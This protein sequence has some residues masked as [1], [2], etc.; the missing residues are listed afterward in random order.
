M[1][2]RGTKE[3]TSRDEVNKLWRS[4][5]ESSSRRIRD[6]CLGDQ[7]IV[8]RPIKERVPSS[9]ETSIAEMREGVQLD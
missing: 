9:N 8:D 2:L 7:T 6:L 1:E 5:V 4:R 3:I